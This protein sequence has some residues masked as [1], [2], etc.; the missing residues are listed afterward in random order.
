LA[1]Q[2]PVEVP[3]GVGDPEDF[4]DERFHGSPPRGVSKWRATEP[5]AR[6]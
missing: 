6:L 1:Q 2:R 3:D 4:C 5:C